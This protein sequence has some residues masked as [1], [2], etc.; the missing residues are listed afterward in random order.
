[1]SRQAQLTIDLNTGMKMR[2]AILCAAGL[3]FWL[4]STLADADPQL[5][6]GASVPDPDPITVEREIDPLFAEPLPPPSIIIAEEEMDPFLADPVPP[7]EIPE[8]TDLDPADPW[9]EEIEE[10]SNGVPLA[11]EESTLIFVP[12]GQGDESPLVIADEERGP[13][14][15][16]HELPAA[17]VFL[18]RMADMNIHFDPR[19]TFTNQA[20]VTLRWDNVTAEHALEEVLD[21]NGLM[22]I[23]N[24]T[25]GIARVTNKPA[26][27]PLVTTLL[28]LKYAHPTNM[29][30][31]LRTTFADPRSKATADLR[32]RQLV[33]VTTA[34]EM[35]AITNMIALL[36]TPSRQVLIEAHLLETSRNPRTIKGIDWSG[37][38]EQ[39]HFVF[40]NGITTG[41]THTQIPGDAGTT[42]LPSGRTVNSH[43]SSMSTRTDLITQIG[44]GGI[45]ANTMRGF[46]PATAFLNADGVR[47]V[48]S[49]L[50]TDSDTEVVASPRA[51][52]LD[53]QMATLSVTR[54]FP[55]FE[56]TPQTVQS[57]A[58]AQITYTNV[59]TILHVT[60]R[61]ST[62]NI[63]AL[64][65][66]P[67]VSNIDSKDRQ[68]IN[69]QANEANVYA[70]RRIE[71][72]VLIPSG[73]TL[74]MGGLMSDT[75]TR[76]HTKVPV[77]GDL[78]GI[79]LAFRRD[80]KARSKANL[81]VFVTPT[82]VEDFDFRPTDTDFLQQKMEFPPEIQES[83]WDS[84]R[85]VNWME[86]KQK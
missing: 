31:V 82:I 2:F 52:T 66:M 44:M 42:T 30:N 18:A 26:Q 48:L 69:G 37:T 55:I 11:E 17:I 3:L 10:E 9:T 4:F 83:A 47:A 13:L 7:A 59:G 19:L 80:S 64:K 68:I 60:P 32:T 72:D 25:T 84:G 75:T 35:Q 51:V 70:V 86:R 74:V 43:N 5:P 36:D 21:N 29:L 78:P 63:I 62:D 6:P 54:A 20:R 56:V 8:E 73:H 76:T 24:D 81:I 57:P 46:H 58:T 67:E 53:N 28:Q 49:F 23:R 33:L 16:D 39:Q 71:T 12:P 65:V 41:T 85:P 34:T 27:A 22:L 40:G 50:N 15:L 79:G 77:L 45:S 61:I 14:I 38:L 1:V